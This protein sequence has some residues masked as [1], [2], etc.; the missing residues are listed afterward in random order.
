[1]VSYNLNIFSLRDNRNV[2]L[3][4]FNWYFIGNKRKILEEDDLLKFSPKKNRIVKNKEQKL[5]IIK[6]V[7]DN[8]K[9]SQEKVASH[10]SSKF[11]LK[12]LIA[13]NTLSNILR[14]RQIIETSDKH[15]MARKKERPPTYP[16]L[17][18]FLMLCYSDLISHN[19]L[20]SDDE[21]LWPNIGIPILRILVCWTVLTCSW[22]NSKTWQFNLNHQIRLHSYSWWM[23]VL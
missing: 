20:L 7:D 2:F 11:N 22:K 10:F 23:L 17:E 18:K 16:A 4:S 13:R 8:P 5:A 19:I 3:I 21:E 15:Q 1:M 9:I 6:F 12:Q 14:N